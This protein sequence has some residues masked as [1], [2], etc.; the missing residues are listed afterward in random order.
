MM[1]KKEYLVEISASNKKFFILIV[2]RESHEAQLIDLYFRQG[3]RLMKELNYDYKQLV[4]QVSYK[5]GQFF[6]RNL[7]DMLHKTTI[8]V[9]E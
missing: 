5:F 4:W 2:D 8:E 7:N 6:I 3:E 1:N 9:I